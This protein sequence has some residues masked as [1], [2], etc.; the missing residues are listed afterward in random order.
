ML[1]GTLPF[2]INQLAKEIVQAGKSPI[3]VP[4][5]GS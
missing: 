2:I 5:V 1:H 4:A 3:G